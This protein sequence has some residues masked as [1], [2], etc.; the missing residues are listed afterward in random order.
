MAGK[1]KFVTVNSI[2]MTVHNICR[3][4]SSIF[5]TAKFEDFLS[6]F[7]DILSKSGKVEPILSSRRAISRPI[8]KLFPQKISIIY[9]LGYWQPN[10]SK[11]WLSRKVEKYCNEV[12]LLFSC[13]D[14]ALQVLGCVDWIRGLFRPLGRESS[15]EGALILTVWFDWISATCILWPHPEP[16]VPSLVKHKT[17]QRQLGRSC[18]IELLKNYCYTKL[19]T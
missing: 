12:Y 15:R 11:P 17:K 19:D 4:R 10:F 6:F 14:I 9:Q 1:Y 7:A 2:K 8:D 3:K 18:A 13:T 5:V 16:S